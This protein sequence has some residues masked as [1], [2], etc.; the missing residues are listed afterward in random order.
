MI[1]GCQSKYSLEMTSSCYVGAVAK[2]LY[3]ACARSAYGAVFSHR[4]TLQA[5]ERRL[6]RFND[7]FQ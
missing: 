3:H 6:L 7:V 4:I 2:Y 1:H 5:I